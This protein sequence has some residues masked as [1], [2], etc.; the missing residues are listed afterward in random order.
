MIYSKFVKPA[1]EKANADFHTAAAKLSKTPIPAA[2]RISFAL[3]V[4]R[5]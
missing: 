1:L 5:R 4:P 3:F 2:V